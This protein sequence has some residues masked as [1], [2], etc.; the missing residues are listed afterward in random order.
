MRKAIAIPPEKV[1]AQLGRLKKPPQQNWIQDWERPST[2]R[3]LTNVEVLM[4]KQGP[5]P[6]PLPE[7]ILNVFVAQWV[8]T[9]DPLVSM[10]KSGLRDPLWYWQDVA[11]RI[12]NDPVTQT[13]IAT[14]EAEIDA[15]TFKPKKRVGKPTREDIAD[16]LE[17]IYQRAMHEGDYSLARSAKSEQAK[18]LGFAKDEKDTPPPPS[19][20]PVD[21][22]SDGELVSLLQQAGVKMPRPGNKAAVVDSGNADPPDGKPAAESAGSGEGAVRKVASEKKP[23]RLR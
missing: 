8:K 2:T 12:L 9:K 4:I 7:K 15:K 20:G 19:S 22:M 18:L 10:V 17:E 21:S 11:N 6:G 5:L 1:A 3:E 13:K 14:L 16:D 23:F